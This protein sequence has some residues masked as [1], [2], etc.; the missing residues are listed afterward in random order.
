MSGFDF[1]L[2]VIAPADAKAAVIDVAA[3]LG[4]DA[5]LSVPLSA[6]GMEPASH[7]GL[8][9]WSRAELVGFLTGAVTPDVDGYTAP[10]LDDVRDMLIVS[11][12]NAAQSAKSVHFHAVCAVHGLSVVAGA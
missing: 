1:S 6:D 11:A 2:V 4:W 7:F 9:A 10:E 3:K 8:H 5:G 12:L